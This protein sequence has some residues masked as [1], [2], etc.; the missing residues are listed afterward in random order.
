VDS[1]W[2]GTSSRNPNQNVTWS[3][4]HTRN[5]NFLQVIQRFWENEKLTVIPT[6]AEERVYTQHSKEYK[7]KAESYLL[8]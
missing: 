5:G 8:M 7:R 6:S 2:K 1:V 3:L 4:F